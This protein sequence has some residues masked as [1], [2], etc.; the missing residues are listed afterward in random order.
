MPFTLVKSLRM[1]NL[2]RIRNVSSNSNASRPR[3]NTSTR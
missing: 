1:F 2:V 3:V